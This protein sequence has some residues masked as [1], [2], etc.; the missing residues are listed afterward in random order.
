MIK[1]S[2]NKIIIYDDELSICDIKEFDLIVTIGNVKDYNLDEFVNYDKFNIW[3][4]YHVIP[5]GYNHKKFLY[6]ETKQYK[7]YKNYYIT[8]TCDVFTDIFISLTQEII[9]NNWFFHYDPIYTCDK[10]LLINDNLF[11]TNSSKILYNVKLLDN[12]IYIFIPEKLLNFYI[13]NHEC[14]YVFNK[15]NI[16][17]TIFK[18]YEFVKITPNHFTQICYKEYYQLLILLCCLTISGIKLPK[19][20]LHK[21]IL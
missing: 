3:L 14:Y 7:R 2:T 11:L 12:K 6:A 21:I 1:I 18:K 8:Y 9:D 5:I 20:I 4:K 15:T 10:M 19:H 13:Y 17:N 16:K